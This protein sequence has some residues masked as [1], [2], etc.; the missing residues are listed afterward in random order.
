MSRCWARARAMARARAGRRGFACPV[1]V[2]GRK[3]QIKT[4]QT[5]PDT[6][7]NAPHCVHNQQQEVRRAG[8]DDA[9]DDGQHQEAAWG[10][11]WR[12]PRRRWRR[13]GV[14]IWGWASRCWW[15][16]GMRGGRQQAP[17]AA[18]GA[19]RRPGRR[20]RCALTRRPC[21]RRVRRSP[22]TVHAR[23]SSRCPTVRVAAGLLAVG[24]SISL[25]PRLRDVR[26]YNT[27]T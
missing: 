8:Q 5:C 21:C 10:R 19:R 18:D 11:R 20:R 3:S 7:H 12:R 15:R 13:R 6:S 27:S 9:N 26:I 14:W 17:P 2:R 25:Q 16:F 24:G 23:R 4:P 22:R 1:I